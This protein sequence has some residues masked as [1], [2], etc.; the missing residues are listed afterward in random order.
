MKRIY[1][2]TLLPLVLFILPLQGLASAS[3]IRSKPS[4]LTICAALVTACLLGSGCSKSDEEENE[5]IKASVD[6]EVAA[7]NSSIITDREADRESTKDSSIAQVSSSQPTVDPE[8][9]YRIIKR[10]AEKTEVLNEDGST[11]LVVEEKIY[12]LSKITDEQTRFH[13]FL[14]LLK[15]HPLTLEHATECA[16][17]L[18]NAD[19]KNEFWKQY[20]ANNKL[21]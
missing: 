7:I 20:F 15:S 12:L 2:L 5:E 14:A 8:L 6:E 9:D 19:N 16:H 18:Q 4:G 21:R 3:A 17:Y 1:A 13:F 10:Y 11:V